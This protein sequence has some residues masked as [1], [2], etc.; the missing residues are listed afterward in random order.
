MKAS[1]RFFFNV[2]YRQDGPSPLEIAGIW[3]KGY[4]ESDMTAS[5]RDR[6]VQEFRKFIRDNPITKGKTVT[7]SR[8]APAF[9]SA[10]MLDDSNQLRLLSQTDL[11]N[12]QYGR[13]IAFVAAQIDYLDGDKL[14][15]ARS[16]ELLQPPAVPTPRIWQTCGVTLGKSD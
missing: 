7:F 14:R 6:V 2:H 11:D 10:Y 16:C 5:T 12:L 3:V 4:E 8:G 9:N 13:E 15:H 1:D